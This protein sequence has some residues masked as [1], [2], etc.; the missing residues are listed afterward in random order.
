MVEN[1]VIPID[2]GQGVD[3][4]TD[5]KL[6][7]PGKML[8]LENGVFTNIKRVAKRN[9]YSALS[10]TV[11]DGIALQGPDLVH[12]YNDQGSNQKSLNPWLV[13]FH[14]QTGHTGLW[15]SDQQ[16]LQV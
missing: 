9:G 1:Q 14:I 5:P 11:S 16:A 12:A 7:V 2:F 8:R 10:T 15:G 3:S 6:V 4:K 13:T